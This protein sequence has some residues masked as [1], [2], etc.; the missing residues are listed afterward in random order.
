MY[1]SRRQYNCICVRSVDVPHGVDSQR[2]FSGVETYDQRQSLSASSSVASL[3]AVGRGSFIRSSASST[4]GSG[5]LGPGGRVPLSLPKSGADVA[6]GSPVLPGAAAHR[7]GQAVSL[8]VNARSLQRNLRPGECLNDTVDKILEGDPAALR[9]VPPRKSSLVYPR[10]SALQSSDASVTRSTS[11]RQTTSRPTTEAADDV[12]PSQQRLS[13]AQAQSNLNLAPV[14]VEA[15]IQRIPFASPM[16]VISN[17]VQSGVA[18][19]PPPPPSSG[20]GSMTGRLTPP[21]QFA[22]AS[23]YR[24]VTPNDSS[25]FA[26]GPFHSTPI[27]RPQ[28]QHAVAV[29]PPSASSLLSRITNDNFVGQHQF[30]DSADDSN[31][32]AE[33]SELMNNP[34]NFYNVLPPPF[35]YGDVSQQQQQPIASSEAVVVKQPFVG[36]EVVGAVNTAPTY[37]QPPSYEASQSYKMAAAMATTPTNHHYIMNDVTASAVRKTN[38]F[39]DPTNVGAIKS[40]AN[41]DSSTTYFP[42]GMLQVNGSSAGLQLPHQMS[43]FTDGHEGKQ[44]G[45]IASA[46]PLKQLSAPLSRPV[47]GQVSVVLE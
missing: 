31:A 37:K 16:T 18:I 6:Y 15:H 34:G 35:V 40:D 4:D 8:V 9:S 27:L 23:E 22:A 47:T 24:H 26:V 5:A 12:W 1:S 10:T 2:A 19:Q 13:S 44:N 14:P 32:S 43:N 45:F 25:S 46:V 11:L 39:A 29:I 41:R 42:N 7:S 30:A 3:K 17:P 21:Y 20:G 28:Y 38:Y 33:P 36:D